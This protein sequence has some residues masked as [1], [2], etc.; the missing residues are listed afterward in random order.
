MLAMSAIPVFWGWRVVLAAFT[1]LTV[2]YGLQFSFGVLL[3]AIARDLDW[4]LST[5]AAPFSLYIFIYTAL[6]FFTGRLTDRIGPLW[7][8][9]V[10]AVC[11]AAGYGSMA[12][13]ET[14]WE[15][16]LYLCVFAALGAG[17][18]FV[19]CNATV[20]KWFVDRRGLALGVA[21]SGI[22]V[23]ALV[24]PPLTALLLTRFDWRD[25]L[26]LLAIGAVVLLL[27]AA[28]FMVRDP[29]SVG[30]RPYRVADAGTPLTLT[31]LT[32]SQAWRTR[33]FWL[34]M[35][36]LFFTWLVIFIPFVHLPGLGAERGLDV[37]SSA[38]LIALAGVGGIAGR[39]FGGPGS[40][41]L[42]RKAG[43]AVA[44]GAQASG[45]YC[46]SISFEFA[47]LGV[48]AFVFGLGYSGV[49]VMFPALLGDLFGRAHSGA[50][51]GFVFASVGSAAAAGPYAASLVFDAT[52]SL[53]GAF[54]GAALVNLVALMLLV[55]L[56]VPKVRFEDR[57]ARG[58]A[59]DGA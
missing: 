18:A 43:L 19:P 55:F 59:Y 25:T 54:H 6:S 7:V 10:G 11:L 42:G 34:L 30:Q 13:T 41:R 24:G 44:I 33:T 50:I 37:S 29:E 12:L 14:V 52:G 16:Y 22:S 56:R 32:L 21:G 58:S 38:M 5:L 57:Q 3:P 46:L 40:D 1:V 17:A 26:V 23:A 53:Q 47:W 15:P 45:L 9:R 20:I 2:I 31:G 35:M 39:L 36:V 4:R 48:W 51:V 28:Q 49:S 8:I 27:A